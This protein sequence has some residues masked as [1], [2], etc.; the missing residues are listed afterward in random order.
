MSVEVRPLGVR[1]N[2]ACT[3]CYQHPMRDAG[4]FGPPYDMEAMLKALE[5][6]GSPFT[7]FGG[8]PLLVP[9][10]DLERLFA[11][12]LERYGQNGVQ[13]NGALIDEEHI[14]LFKRYRVHVGFSID[15]PEELN[16]LRWA[17]S[18]ESTDAATRRSIENLKRLLREGVSASLIVTI[19]RV[20]AGD[21][22]KRARLGDFLVDLH[23]AGLRYMR[24]H[25]LEVDGPLARRYALEP[26]EAAEAFI[27]L[28]GRLRKEA[29]GLQVDVFQDIFAG[30][31]GE[32]ERIT[33]IWH[34]CD[35]LTTRAVQGVDGD[36]RRSNCGRT[37]KEGIDWVKAPQ[38]GYERYVALYQT[39][40]EYGG[41]QGCRFFALCKG[42][43]PGTALEGDFR[44]RSDQ[45][46]FWYALMEYA[47][48]RLEE[49]GIT[50]ISRHP[51]R[52]AIEAYL[53]QGWREGRNPTIAEALRAL[54]G[55][56]SGKTWYLPVE[57]HGDHTDHGDAPHGDHWDG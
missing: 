53:V 1:C 18:V 43:C 28:W 23:R 2:L 34:A 29:P 9:K 52:E 21:A 15:G 19:H 42:N 16:R 22:E 33:C 4:A 45:C 37:A 38:A 47:E 6:E 11:F 51:Q 12:G 13:T 27:Y 14:A 20:N 24:L 8:E 40:Q 35:P 56:L 57:S 50:P 55:G 7:V 25:A 10:P 31:R 26:Q 48:E 46:E 54:S 36:G 30:L 17:G 5:A 41:C 32:D 3:Y 49:V 44:N 39:P